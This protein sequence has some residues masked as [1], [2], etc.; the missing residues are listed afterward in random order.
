M[1]NS[2]ETVVPRQWGI[3][4]RGF[5]IKWVRKGKVFAVGRLQSRVTFRAFISSSSNRI[6][7]LPCLKRPLAG[8]VV[9][10]VLKSIV[11]LRKADVLLRAKV[12][13]SNSEESLLMT[14]GEKRKTNNKQNRTMT[15]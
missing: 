10:K 9:L 1:N 6:R 5:G 3:E 15:Y 11:I 7:I 4:T 8:S 12:I 14:S 2:K 13:A